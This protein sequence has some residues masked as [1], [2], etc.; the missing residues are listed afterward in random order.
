VGRT[1]PAVI[2]PQI[3]R[4]T[5]FGVFTLCDTESVVAVYPHLINAGGGELQ[6]SQNFHAGIAVQS[7]RTRDSWER[8][9]RS[10]V[11]RAGSRGIYVEIDHVSI[12][13]VAAVCGRREVGVVGSVQPGKLVLGPGQ[14]VGLD[15]RGLVGSDPETGLGEVR[16]A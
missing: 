12:I 10:K 2:L 9:V 8:T 1:T 6:E 14:A 5:V 11:A 4:E 15:C 16:R 7:I 3:Q 13:D